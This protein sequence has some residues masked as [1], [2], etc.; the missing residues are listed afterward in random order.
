MFFRKFLNS[1]Q[2]FVEQGKENSH[3]LVNRKIFLHLNS[4]INFY[5]FPNLFLTMTTP[6]EG[7]IFLIAV[8]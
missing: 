1:K 7:I 8:Q 3:R 4:A 6:N 2:I 5:I